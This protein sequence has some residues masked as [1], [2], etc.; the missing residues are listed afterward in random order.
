M[1]SKP[2]SIILVA[3]VDSQIVGMLDFSA[4][5]RKRIAH[6][7]NFGVSINKYFRDDGIGK[8]LIQTLLNWAA[9]HPV[10]EKVNLKVHA[11]NSRAISLYQKLGFIEEGL[12]RNELK[13]SNG[14]Y[15][16]SVEMC[17]F[18]K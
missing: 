14:Q 13:Y 3:T 1:A 17:K 7:G 9:Q 4:G 18:V 5:H 15:V 12:F 11:T 16:D 6:T 8:I 2:S 10:I